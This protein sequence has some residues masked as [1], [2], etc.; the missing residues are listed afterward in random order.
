MCVRVY[1]VILRGLVQ[2]GHSDREGTGYRRW[3]QAPPFKVARLHGA[4]RL[5]S[6]K[7]LFGVIALFWLCVIYYSVMYVLPAPRKYFNLLLPKPLS[8][9]RM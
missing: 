2:L 8:L 9:S 3:G 5:S 6:E 1:L 4:L 7:V